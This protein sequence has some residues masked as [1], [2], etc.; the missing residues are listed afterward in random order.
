[1]LGAPPQALRAL[2]DLGQR[3][4]AHR[5]ARGLMA[6]DMA[7]RLLCSPATYRALETGRPGTSIGILA[8]ALWLLG[9]LDS[10]G[11]TA[12]MDTALAASLS[13]GRRVR[14]SAGKVA[15]GTIGQHERDF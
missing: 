12:P 2:I 1:M 8:H 11:Q 10:L 3:L 15:A 13:A 4:R 9:Q 6:A 7:Q 5:V 14:R